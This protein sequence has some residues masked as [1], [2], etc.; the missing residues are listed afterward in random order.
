MMKRI[1]RLCLDAVE[2]LGPAVPTLAIIKH[3]EAR[4]W[5]FSP[6]VQVHDA[7]RRLRA[8]QLVVSESVPGGPER[9]YYRNLLWTL[10]GRNLGLHVTG[11]GSGEGLSAQGGVIGRA[12]TT[13]EPLP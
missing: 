3:V 5:M 7:L 2:K 13:I 9:G 4:R 8:A 11:V 10:P 1:D 6:V 12:N